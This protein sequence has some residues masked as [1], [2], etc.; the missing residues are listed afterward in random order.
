MDTP[1][2]TTAESPQVDK[3]QFKSEWIEIELESVITIQ[4]VDDLKTK[5]EQYKN[6]RVQLLGKKIK[7]IDT[8]AFQLLLAFTNSKN[9]TVVWVEPSPE[10]C[11][12]AELLGLSTAA[13]LSI[14]KN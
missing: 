6:C 14:Q 5:L 8:A 9:F 4:Q 11:D 10:L 3:E 2:E 1:N 12:V 13:G 7:R